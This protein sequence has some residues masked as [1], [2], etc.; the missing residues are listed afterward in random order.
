MN[1]ATEGLRVMTSPDSQY[2]GNDSHPVN[3]GCSFYR[4][5]NDDLRNRTNLNG[6][7]GLEKTTC[8]TLLF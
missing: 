6:K 3:V 5:T 7:H 8:T 4:Y 2:G 1:L